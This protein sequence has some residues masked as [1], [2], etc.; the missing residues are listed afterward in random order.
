MP[1]ENP[2]SLAFAGHQLQSASVSVKSQSSTKS[3]LYF[4]DG[5]RG[6]AA[7][8]VLAYHTVIFQSQ[9]NP[10]TFFAYMAVDY[11]F[12]LS[13]FVLF[14][15]INAKATLP[16]WVFTFRRALRLWPLVTIILLVSF[17]NECLQ[18]VIV[19][20]KSSN[21]PLAD[22]PFEGKTLAGWL[23]ALC[24]LQVIF[25]S[26]HVWWGPLWSLSVEWLVNLLAIL[27]R[28]VDTYYLA[29]GAV[30]LGSIVF[31]QWETF[32]LS[33]S[34][35]VDFGY[36]GFARALMTFF[37]G[38]AMAKLLIGR[39]RL[40]RTP[41]SAAIISLLAL[42]LAFLSS[43]LSDLPVYR[44]AVSSVAAFCTLYLLS[45][46]VE[47]KLSPRSK[48]F[49]TWLGRLSFG[50][51]LWHLLFSSWVNAAAR[52]IFNESTGPAHL[53]LQSFDLIVTIGLSLGAAYL[54]YKY[55]EPLLRRQLAKILVVPD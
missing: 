4:L 39:K 6:I 48:I 15:Q 21:V 25:Q 1:E 52:A 23:L 8:V 9:E 40:L 34:P 19:S 18:W 26:A 16:A 3:R 22:N 28:R 10:L 32:N 20:A 44:A 5:S 41:L 49:L 53:F 27:T 37:P 51:Y 17:L 47:S 14:S 36:L 42:I 33:T 35:S 7:L 55:F 46:V 54:S 38:M 13:G 50:V 31:W 11:F 43:G 12:A 45:S 30:A 24:L 29:V 2:P